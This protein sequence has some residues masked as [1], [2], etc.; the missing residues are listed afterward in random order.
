MKFKKS[1][2]SVLSLIVSFLLYL[3]AT[4]SSNPAFPGAV[5]MGADSVGGRGGSVYVVDTLSDNPAAGVTFREACE[6]SGARYVVFAVSGII[7]LDSILEITD[8]YITIAGETSPGGILITG[9]SVRI[10]AHDVIMRH[11]RIR[12]GCSKCYDAG[13]CETKGDALSIYGYPAPY[14]RSD[15]LDSYNIIIDHCSISW[16]CDETFDFAAENALVEKITV[17]NCIIAE[18]VNDAHP[19]GNHARGLFMWG[20]HTM[21]GKTIRVSFYQNLV[22]SFYSRLPLANYNVSFDFIN[23]VVY[24]FNN[25]YAP[26]IEPIAGYMITTNMIHNYIKPGPNSYSVWNG[27]VGGLEL[28]VHGDGSKGHVSGTPYE[29]IYMEGNIGYSRPT[30]TGSDWL[31]TEGWSPTDLLEK[32]Y[33]RSTPFASPNG[34]AITPVTMSES[35]ATTIVEQAGATVPSRDSVDTRLVSEYKAGNAGDYI[36]RADV[37]A[38]MPVFSTPAAPT[39]SDG[40]GMSDA[41]E[42][43]TFGDLSKKATGDEDSDGYDNIEAYLHYLA[44]KRAPIDVEVPEPQNLR[45]ES[46]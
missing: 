28:V 30:Q 10:K 7:D 40:D 38:L 14:G 19:E 4:A 27:S 20:K 36:N 26:T 2:I 3:P 39:D 23:N 43:I 33:R 32:D 17:S 46:N 11:V 41:W 37:A 15:R 6:A 34:V 25:I 1:N 12:N 21:E 22:M 42:S 13:N 16:G 18:G 9:W 31:V 8:P 35:Y 44:D 29:M 24:N 45:I 5:G